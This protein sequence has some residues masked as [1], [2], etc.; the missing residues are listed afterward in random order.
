MWKQKN[1]RVNKIKI[2]PSIHRFYIT[3]TSYYNAED[4]FRLKVITAQL[5]WKQKNNKVNI[6]ANLPS[7]HIDFILHYITL[8]HYYNAKNITFSSQVITAQ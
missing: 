3:L 4:T 5:M 7:I 6:M 8:T 1:N 2:L